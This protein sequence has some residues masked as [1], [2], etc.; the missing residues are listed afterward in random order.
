MK[1]IK[2]KTNR[3]REVEIPVYFPETRGSAWDAKPEMK[4]CPNCESYV[5]KQVAIS[6]ISILQK[7]EPEWRPPEERK[8]KGLCIFFDFPMILLESEEGA[9]DCNL[10]TMDEP[11]QRQFTN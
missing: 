5:S 6:T 4:N 2:I 7:A 9:L 1:K 10:K 3:S 8:V 11:F